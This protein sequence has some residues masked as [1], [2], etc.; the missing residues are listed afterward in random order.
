M[1]SDVGLL[2]LNHSKRTA[3]NL[4]DMHACSLACRS[5]GRKMADENPEENVDMD[6][7]DTEDSHSED[8]SDENIAESTECVP[9]E[10]LDNKQLSFE[11]NVILTHR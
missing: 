9:D 2:W 5:K 10:P 6:Y 11:P 7:E 8:S 4:R 1:T 3:L